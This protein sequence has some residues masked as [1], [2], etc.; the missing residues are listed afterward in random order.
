MIITFGLTPEQ[1]AI[2]A[3]ANA[4]PVILL[5]TEDAP[6]LNPA[7]PRPPANKKKIRRT[8]GWYQTE[9]FKAKERIRHAKYNTPEYRE[10]KRA[11]DKLHYQA[12]KAKIKERNCN[13]EY[14]AIKKARDRAKYVARTAKKAADR[15]AIHAAHLTK[16][17]NAIR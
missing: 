17:Y 11:R 9:E 8:E 7:P 12:H 13:P 2:H 16:E 4:K 6:R 5:G 10:K 1:A 15:D 14:I 3:R